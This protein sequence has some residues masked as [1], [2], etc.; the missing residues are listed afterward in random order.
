MKIKFKEP[1]TTQVIN[2]IEQYGDEIKE[3]QLTYHEYIQFLEELHHSD[4]TAKMLL[5]LPERKFQGVPISIG[6]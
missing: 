3:I 4:L 6:D 2:A 5:S 1:I